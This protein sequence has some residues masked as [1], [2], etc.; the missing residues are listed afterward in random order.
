[1]IVGVCFGVFFFLLV[2]IIML[3]FPFRCLPKTSSECAGMWH[4]SWVNQ[5]CSSLQEVLGFM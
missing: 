5:L 2:S 1:M 4:I 3:K